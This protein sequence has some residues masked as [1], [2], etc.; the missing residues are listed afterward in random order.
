M[1]VRGKAG[2]RCWGIAEIIGGGVRVRVRVRVGVGVAVG[3]RVRRGVWNQRLSR[4]QDE[5]G[6]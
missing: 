3:V 2:G 4:P 6:R 5:L 1:T